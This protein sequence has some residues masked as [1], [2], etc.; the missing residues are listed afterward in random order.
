MSEE[1]EMFLEKKQDTSPAKEGKEEQEITVFFCES[2]T[3]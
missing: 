2:G 3:N 1:T